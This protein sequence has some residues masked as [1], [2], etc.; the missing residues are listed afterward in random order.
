[1]CSFLFS[2]GRPEFHLLV[3]YP[4]LHGFGVELPWTWTLAHAYFATLPPSSL[5]LRCGGLASTTGNIKLQARMRW[6][7]RDFNFL[8]SHT[9]FH[10]HTIHSTPNTTQVTFH[11]A[12]DPAT[13]NKAGNWASVTSHTGGG[14]G[15]NRA[16]RD[17]HRR[18]R[19]LLR[20]I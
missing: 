4:D 20:S 2:F 15:G 11:Y 12:F 9:V 5:Y 19:H 6:L 3:G 17:L 16:G 18:S 14:E 1:M 7:G 8:P 10:H 13:S